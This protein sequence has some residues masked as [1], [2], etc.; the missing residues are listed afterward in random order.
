MNKIRVLIVEPNREPYQKRINHTLEDMQN[1]V[2]GLLEY[3]ELEHNVDL[4]YNEEGKIYNLQMN[5][6]IQNDIIAG[7]FFIAGQHKGE[8]IS[9]SKKQ[10]KKY[11]EIFRLEQD[12]SLIELLRETV[13]ES[14]NLLNLRLT[15]VGNWRGVL[16][17]KIK[18]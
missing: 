10:I 9:L 17:W 13:K 14:S 4:I 6:A 2:G 12:K 8:T 3:I 7:T 18:I 5:R 1:I 11:K 16:K 15:N